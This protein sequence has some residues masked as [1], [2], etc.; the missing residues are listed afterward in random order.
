MFLLEF[1]ARAARHSRP[2]RQGLDA[3]PPLI[4]LILGANIGSLMLP[5]GN[6]Q[7]A[8]IMMHADIAFADYARHMIPIA[9]ACLGIA[10][11]LL[12]LARLPDPRGRRDLRHELVGVLAVA[13][14]AVLAAAKS[15][16]AIGEWVADAPP[17]VLR[18][19]GVRPDP[20]DAAIGSWLSSLTP[21]AGAR[22]PIHRPL[23]RAVGVDGKTL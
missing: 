22:P 10:G 11:L 23:R 9:L 21:M 6:P 7:Q 16:T 2:R 14:C 17:Q 15:F 1:D 4:A 19:L 20:L 13:V 18:A 5:I 3:L 8:F 12:H